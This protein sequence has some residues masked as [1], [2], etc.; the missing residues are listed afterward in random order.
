MER[1][2]SEVSLPTRV[3]D[4]QGVNRTTLAAIDSSTDSIRLLE[5][6]GL[7]GH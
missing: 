4:L 7:K 6:K 2:Q 5:A 1:T 3:L